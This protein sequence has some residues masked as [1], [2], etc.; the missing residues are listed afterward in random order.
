MSLME[1]VC[2]VSHVPLPCLVST[3][4]HRSCPKWEEFHT[5]T[6]VLPH[7]GLESIPAAKWWFKLVTYT[8][9]RYVLALSHFFSCLLQVELD[10]YL[11]P[12]LLALPPSFI[13]APACV[14]RLEHKCVI[15]WVLIHAHMSR[16]TEWNALTHSQLRLSSVAKVGCTLCKMAN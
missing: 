10:G 7:V 12:T 15:W 9:K 13:T 5:S 16:L 4:S 14:E 8:Y 6:V 3:T 2:W 1:D 11:W